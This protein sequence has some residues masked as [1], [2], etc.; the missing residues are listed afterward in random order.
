MYNKVIL[1]GRMTHQ[2]ELRTTASGKYVTSFTLAVDRYVKG[3]E[4]KADF[5]TIVAWEK[6]AETICRFFFKGSQIGVDGSIQ[7]RNYEDKNGNKR[8]AV[9]VLMENFFFVDSLKKEP[10]DD[11]PVNEPPVTVE[12]FEEAEDEADLPF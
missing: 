3:G 12:D 6:R 8:T 7:T 2:P 5:I 10:I 11:T 9:E 1:V 4:K